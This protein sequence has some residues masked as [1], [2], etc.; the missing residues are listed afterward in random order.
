MFQLSLLDKE[1]RLVTAGVSV[2]EAIGLFKKIQVGARGA[3]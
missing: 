2:T 3:L 1:Q